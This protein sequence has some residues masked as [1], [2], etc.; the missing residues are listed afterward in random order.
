[1]EEDGFLGNQSEVITHMVPRELRDLGTVEQK[2]SVIEIIEPLKKAENG[3]FPT[4]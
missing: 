3:R 1:L 2:F 4:S